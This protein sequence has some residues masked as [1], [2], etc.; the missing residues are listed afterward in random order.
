V[1]IKR[2]PVIQRYDEQADAFRTPSFNLQRVML[3]ILILIKFNH[4][5]GKVEVLAEPHD[6]KR[7]KLVVH[8]TG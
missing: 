4:D 6:T 5:G 2:S 3:I 8:D 7:F 1:P